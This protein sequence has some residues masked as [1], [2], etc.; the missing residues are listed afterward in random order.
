MPRRPLMRRVGEGFQGR[1]PWCMWQTTVV[2]EFDLIEP[3][4]RVHIK[5]EHVSDG[6]G[7]LPEESPPEAS[8]GG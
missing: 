4:I 1:C 2:A 7:D 3:E 8:N 6:G 5:E